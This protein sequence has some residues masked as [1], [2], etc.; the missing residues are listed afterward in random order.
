VA[1]GE[2]SVDN[3]RRIE[4]KSWKRQI[5]PAMRD[6]FL[7]SQ[8]CYLQCKN[9]PRCGGSDDDSSYLRPATKQREPHAKEKEHEQ[10]PM[11]QGKRTP[12]SG[13]ANGIR[14]KTAKER[15][16]G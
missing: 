7:A 14:L 5:R 8:Q 16:D 3:S 13:Q 15:A 4:L 11:N 6:D 9:E 10:E 12:T 2:C 1:P